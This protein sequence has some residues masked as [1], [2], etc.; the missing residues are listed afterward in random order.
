MRRICSTG[1]M[2]LFMLLF[3]GPVAASVEVVGQVVNLMIDKSDQS[4]SLTK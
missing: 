2:L 4:G 3:S 1:L